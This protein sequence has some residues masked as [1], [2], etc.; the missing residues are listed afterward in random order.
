MRDISFSQFL[1]QYR[2]QII[3]YFAVLAAL[4]ILRNSEFIA[5]YDNIVVYGTLAIIICVASKLYLA[6]PMRRQQ[7]YNLGERYRRFLVRN[8]TLEDDERQD[9]LKRLRET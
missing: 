7:A 9:Y 3:A 6:F 2:K 4:I 8:P 1:R 5:A